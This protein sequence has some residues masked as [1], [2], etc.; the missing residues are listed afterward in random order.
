MIKT[1]LKFQ[2]KMPAIQTLLH[3]QRITETFKFQAQFDLNGQG[4]QF[5]H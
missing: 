2:S 1:Q 5:S 3:L 4:H